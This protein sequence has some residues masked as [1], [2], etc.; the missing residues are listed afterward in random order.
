MIEQL[1]FCELEFYDKYVICRINEGETISFEKSKQQTEAILN[2]YKNKPFIYITH[3]VN[4]YAVDPNIYANSSKIKTLIGFVVVS[5][6]IASVK[7]AIF[8]R[9]FLDKPFE[10]FNDISDA[11]M[12]ADE[13]YRMKSHTFDTI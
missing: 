1:N 6:N 13:V 2:Y 3:R 10:I 12:W 4:S 8:E 5:S 7:N 11:T 9:M